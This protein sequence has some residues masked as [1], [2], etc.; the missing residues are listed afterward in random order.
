M[1]L[2]VC[3]MTREKS[4]D[5]S[6]CILCGECIDGCAKKALKMRFKR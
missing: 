3:E 5:T 1:S 2:N 6:D 4:S